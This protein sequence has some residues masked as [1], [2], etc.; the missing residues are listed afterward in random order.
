MGLQLDAFE[1]HMQSKQTG[2]VFD[3]VIPQEQAYGT[4][5]EE[6]VITVPRSTFEVDGHFDKEHIYEGAVV[7]LVDSEGHR[8]PCT[9]VSLGAEEVVV[10]L[11]Y[12]LSGHDLHF[13]GEVMEARLATAEEVQGVQDMLQS[14]GGCSCGCDHSDCGSDCA[15]CH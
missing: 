6:K 2:D 1:E 14:E 4:R 8:F 12:P 15:G 7:P 10:D 13:V 5:E 3:F 9:I 11:N